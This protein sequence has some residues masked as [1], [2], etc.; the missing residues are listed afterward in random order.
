M[1]KEDE[2]VVSLDKRKNHE[3]GIERIEDELQTTSRRIDAMKMKT[4]II[5]AVSFFFLYRMVAAAWTGIP[6]ARLPFMPVKFVQNLSFRG[7]PGDDKY[8]CSFG[9]IYTLC[10]LGVKA[11]IPKAFGFVSPK[12]A[13]DASRMAARDARKSS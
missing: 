3:K 1:A 4:N 12:S 9:L 5:A 10:T 11:N 8:Q 13:F 2:K 7:L 6:V